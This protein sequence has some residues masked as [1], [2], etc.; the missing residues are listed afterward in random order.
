MQYDMTI[1]T[2]RAVPS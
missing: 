1:M 2:K